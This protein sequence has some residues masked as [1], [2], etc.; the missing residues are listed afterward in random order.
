MEGKHNKG[1]AM[2]VDGDGKK[3]RNYDTFTEQNLTAAACWLLALFVIRKGKM[4]HRKWVA[5]CS[6]LN[7]H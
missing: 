1:T 4:F 2:K 5:I 3:E 7:S 6:S